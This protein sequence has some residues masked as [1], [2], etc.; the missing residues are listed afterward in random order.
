MIPTNG[1]AAIKSLCTILKYFI[2][3]SLLAL[4]LKHFVTIFRKIFLKREA[5][6]TTSSFNG[7][8]PLTMLSKI[9]HTE[10]NCSFLAVSSNAFPCFT[11]ASV[12]A[13]R[14]ASLS[15]IRF[16][17]QGKRATSVCYTMHNIYKQ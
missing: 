7:I 1:K 16:M 3:S 12:V 9:S 14:K 10:S 8:D 4:L 13:F 5:F 15:F 6:F 17:L 2:I 11:C